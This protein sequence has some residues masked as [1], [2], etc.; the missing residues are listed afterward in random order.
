M[1]AGGA[2]VSTVHASCVALDG[3]AALILGRS[4]A[5]KSALCLEMMAR[6]AGLVADDRV[7]LWREGGTVMAEAPTPIKGLIEA[8]GVGLL[9][10]P[11]VGPAA[12]ALVVDLDVEETQ[13]LPP[14][15]QRDVL[16][17]S[18]PLCH[19]SVHGHFPAALIVYLQGGRY[20]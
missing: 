3:R 17:L 11:P 1:G 14:E 16:G 2:A 7:R 4:G 9:H 5:G 13:R 18:L 10:A 6:G 15:R 20:A 12:V 8:R 19:K